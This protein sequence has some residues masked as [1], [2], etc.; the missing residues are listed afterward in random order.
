MTPE[1]ATLAIERFAAAC[2]GHAL[3]TAAFLGGSYAAGTAS[4]DSDIDV[5]A[6]CNEDDYLAFFAERM[7]FVRSWT[8]GATLV[9]VPNFE[10]LG[11]DLIT[12]ECSGG[13]WGQLVLGHTGNLMRLHGGPHVVLVDKRRLLKGVEFPLL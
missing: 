4:E 12:F 9:D 8:D 2:A 3:V 6:V 7:S 10:G 1:Q 11:F 13:V 5:Y